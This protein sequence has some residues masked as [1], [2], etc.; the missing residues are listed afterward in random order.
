[1][2]DHNLA[3][4]DGIMDRTDP[5]AQLEGMVRGAWPITIAFAYG[6][7]VVRFG[8]REMAYADTLADA[9]AELARKVGGWSPTRRTR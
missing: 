8:T 6:K 5:L 3:V 2:K 9:I 1:M 4:S 7:F